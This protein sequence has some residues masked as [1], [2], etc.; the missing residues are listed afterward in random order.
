MSLLVTGTI[1][2]DTVETPYGKAPDVL[3]GSAVYF[4]FAA[5]LLSPVRLVG[6]V[7]EDFPAGFRDLLKTRPIDTAGLE[8]R[9]GSKTFRW[10]G[11]YIGDMNSAETL[12]TDLNIIAEAAPTIPAAFRDSR[13]VFLANTHPAVQ[14]EFIRQLSK[15][16][17]IVCDTM[18]FWISDHRAELVKTL[19]EVHGVVLNDGEA[20]M[21]TGANNLILA[22]KEVLKLGPKFAVIK[23]G[24][25]GAMLVTG[26]QLFVLPAYPTTKV[27]DPTGAGDS[28]AGGLMG[29]LASVGKSDVESIKSAMAR[30]ACIASITIESFSLDSIKAAEKAEVE[31]RLAEFRRLTTYA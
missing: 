11:K 23:K 5:S 16:E 13:F 26:D 20:R 27:V 30:G 7:G 29:Y 18:N 31:R 12:R 21:L 9:K 14:R 1:G 3:G 28:F 10:S 24:E 25:H 22:A 19:G 6:A 17:L 15:P 2:I 8:T 4:A